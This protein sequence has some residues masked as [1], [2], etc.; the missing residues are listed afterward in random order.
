MRQT[1]FNKHLVAS[2]NMSQRKPNVTREY[3][4]NKEKHIK[5]RNT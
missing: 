3:V 1:L 5:Y 2:N 4:N